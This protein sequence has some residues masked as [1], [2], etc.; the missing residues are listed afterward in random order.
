MPVEAPPAQFWKVMLPLLTDMVAFV[1]KVICTP[2]LL[3]E[4][5]PLA[6]AVPER[7]IFPV[8]VI[9]VDAAITTPDPDPDDLARPV[10][11]MLPVVIDIVPL[12]VLEKPWLAVPPFPPIPLK[13]ILPVL[14][15]TAPPREIPGDVPVAALLVAVIKIE[16]VEASVDVLLKPIDA[17][18]VPL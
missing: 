12:F 15:V 7:T 18:P 10:I 1:G 13:T 17:S 14:T 2:Q 9:V 3:S 8:P 4:E 16:F 6:V 11:V 5:T